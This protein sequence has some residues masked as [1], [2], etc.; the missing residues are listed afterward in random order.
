VEAPKT[1]SIGE[2][3]SFAW[4]AASKN[5]G[6]FLVIIIMM[7]LLD[8]CGVAFGVIAQ[9]GDSHRLRLIAQVLHFAVQMPL[10]LWVW[11]GLVAASIRLASGQGIELEDFFPAL[12]PVL[13]YWMGSFLW[14]LLVLVGT[15]CLVV[16]GILLGLQFQFVPY[17]MLDQ[18]LGWQAAFERSSRMTAGEKAKLFGYAW[19]CLGVLLL[20]LLAC[21]V[22]VFWALICLQIA[23]ASIY[24][25][26]LVRADAAAGKSVS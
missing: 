12:G 3:L 4:R 10:G 17:L 22:G 6:L 5:I 19:V 21:C 26:L 13:R 18:G 25:T 23:T 14:C 20:G 8:A 24:R 15:L 11:A 16:P 9:E 7:V 2:A 1:F